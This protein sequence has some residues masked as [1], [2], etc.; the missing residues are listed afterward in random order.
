MLDTTM[1]VTATWDEEASV[2][3]ATSDDIDGLAVEADTL[4]RLEKKV[5]DAVSDL[6]E[7]NGVGP[8]LAEIPV[9]LRT[10]HILKIPNPHF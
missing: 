2:W 1:V 4:E 9:R 3:F 7:L 6:L 10:E 5:A 8:E